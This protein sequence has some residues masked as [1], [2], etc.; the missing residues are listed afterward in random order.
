VPLPDAPLIR[1]I[2]QVR[3]P[4]ILKVQKP[5]E[6]SVFQEQIGSTYPILRPEHVQELTF[7]PRGVASDAR[8]TVWRF[9]DQTDAWRVTLAQDFVAVETTKYDSRS[10]FLGRLEAVVRALE[11]TLRPAQ[12]ERL[13]IRYIDRITGDAVDKIADLVRRE[14]LGVLATPL[15]DRILHSIFDTVFALPD[16]PERLRARWGKLPAGAVLDPSAIEPIEA[17]SWVLDLDMFSTEVRPFTTEVIIADARKYAE[18]VY[19]MF[20]WVVTDKFLRRY[21][22]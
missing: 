1:V 20:R 9:S 2:A 13:G 15:S 16:G 10:V 14:M 22:G 21:G 19:A 4:T 3:F 18:R 5:D 12:M 8:Q 7:G 6:I 17:P 11:T